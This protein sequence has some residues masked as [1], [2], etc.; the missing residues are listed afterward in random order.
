MPSGLATYRSP[1][2]ISASSP[3]APTYRS[4]GC[5]SWRGGDRLLDVGPQRVGPFPRPKCADRR[6]ASD[7]SRDKR[8]RSDEHRAPTDVRIRVGQRPEHRRPCPLLPGE[9]ER[10][11]DLGRQLVPDMGREVGAQGLGKL[12]VG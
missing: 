4:T 10:G 11:R 12:E 6:G 9:V 8:C 5:T 7:R 2:L 1:P 3:G